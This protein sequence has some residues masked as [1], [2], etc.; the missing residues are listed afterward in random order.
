MSPTTTVTITVNGEPRDV[1]GDATVQ[2][3][4][5]RLPG[6]PAGLAVAVNGVVVPARSW[7]ATPLRAADTVE[8]VTAHQGG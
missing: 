5:G 4:A 2:D 6:A 8:V 3:V 7:S 1:P